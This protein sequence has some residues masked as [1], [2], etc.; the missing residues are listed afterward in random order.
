MLVCE[1]TPNL[2]HVK[3]F[4]GGVL[5]GSWNWCEGWRTPGSGSGQRAGRYSPGLETEGRFP[6]KGPKETLVGGANIL[7]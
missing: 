3:G 6:V 2:A 4:I 7:P 5:D 1:Q